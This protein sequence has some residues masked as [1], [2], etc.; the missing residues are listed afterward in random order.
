MQG[1]VPGPP[2]PHF[3]QGL[4]PF[5]GY[6]AT[7]E[8]R[9]LDDRP[10]EEP[11]WADADGALLDQFADVGDWEPMHRPLVKV[12]AVIVSVS[13]VVA[14]IGHRARGLALGPMTYGSFLHRELGAGPCR[15]P[16]SVVGDDNVTASVS[17]PKSIRVR[18]SGAPAAS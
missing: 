15:S 18:A 11:A 17:S 10:P 16:Y 6:L 3:P 14:G 7:R 5:I 8:P 1:H 13:L 4:G 9:P 12:M 2:Q